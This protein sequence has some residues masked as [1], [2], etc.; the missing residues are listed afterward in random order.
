MPNGKEVSH[1]DKNDEAGGNN[2]RRAGRECL[3]DWPLQVDQQEDGT[4]ALVVRS[5][6]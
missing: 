4:C 3:S 2:G 5:A 1:K 6:V